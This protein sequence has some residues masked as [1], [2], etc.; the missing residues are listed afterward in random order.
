M[1]QRPVDFWLIAGDVMDVMCREPGW[2][3]TCPGGSLGSGWQWT[4]EQLAELGTPW[5]AVPGNHDLLTLDTNPWGQPDPAAVDA[6]QQYAGPLQFVQ[7]TERSRIVG[8]N[9]L[10]WSEGNRAWL[11]AQLDTP[12]TKIV[13]Q[14]FPLAGVMPD[15]YWPDIYAADKLAFLQVCGVSLVLTGHRH[16][17]SISR[18]GSLSH[19]VLP[20]ISYIAGDG[21]DPLADAIF[22]MSYPMRGWIEITDGDVLTVELFRQDGQRVWEFQAGGQ[23]LFFPFVAS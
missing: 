12:K 20:A 8:L 3:F 22:P 16:Q 9:Y 18:I 2:I 13:V 4:V 21:P 10:D 14:H 7:E 17:F 5:F 1:A 11:A 6:W 15:G 23:E 19:I